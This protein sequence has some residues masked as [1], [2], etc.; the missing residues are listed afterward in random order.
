V[1]EGRLSEERIDESV[2]RIL[3]LKTI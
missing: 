2:R 3:R 1:K